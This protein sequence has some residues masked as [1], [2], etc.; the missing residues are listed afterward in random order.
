VNRPGEFMAAKRLV[1]ERREVSAERLADDG[2]PLKA[3]L[4]GRG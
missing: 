3:L 2:A 4:S 1:G